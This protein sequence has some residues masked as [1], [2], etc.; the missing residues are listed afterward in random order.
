MMLIHYLQ[1]KRTIPK[2]KKK[3]WLGL[4]S[5]DFT[6][7]YR[8]SFTLVTDHKPLL[9]Q[10]ISK[11]PVPAQASARI[12]RWA[13]TLP[14][15]EYT[16]AFKNTIQHSNA[17]ALSRLPLKETVEAPLP[18]QTVSLLQFLDKVPV[19][20]SQICTWTRRDPVLSKVTEYIQI[21]WQIE[22]MM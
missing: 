6:H 3:P 11:K 14:M 17:D 18:Q 8:S 15:Y 19:S 2:W 5:K 9:S 4:E 21:K 1:L 10:L 7:T 12:Q 20:A 22:N 16:L 13:L